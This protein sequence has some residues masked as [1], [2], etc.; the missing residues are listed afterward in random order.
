M[1]STD[2]RRPVDL[3]RLTIHVTHESIAGHV[4]AAD[5]CASDSGGRLVAADED[6]PCAPELQ[7]KRA[8]VDDDRIEPAV[9]RTRVRRDDD[10]V[11]VLA[12][13]RER[14][15]ESRPLEHLVVQF[16]HVT[17]TSVRPRRRERTGDVAQRAAA[18]AMTKGAGDRGVEADARKIQEVPIR[19]KAD[20]QGTGGA[21]SADRN[22]CSAVPRKPSPRARPLPDPAGTMPSAV[23]DPTSGPAAW[24]IVPSPPQAT[25]TS[26]PSATN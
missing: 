5:A 6:A 3:E 2:V 18:A 8:G 13:V 7:R 1:A 22:A 24:L 10:A 4:G 11:A 23:D 12:P 17:R 26:M 14:Q 15:Q 19:E 9:A 20:V 16:H 21:V 25:T